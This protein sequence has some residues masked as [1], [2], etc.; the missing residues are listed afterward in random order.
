[1][2]NKILFLETP[3]HKMLLINYK[4]KMVIL[5]WR[6]MPGKKPQVTPG[7]GICNTCKSQR[8]T[9]S[10]GLCALLS[11]SVLSHSLQPHGLQPAG[12]LRPWGFSRQEYWSG[13]PC[14]SP[15]DLL[16]PGTEPKSRIVGGF[17]TILAT[18]EAI[19]HIPRISTNQHLYYSSM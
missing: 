10:Y 1:M 13:L 15:G 17:F 2:R 9:V 6:N 19:S 14:P 3:F 12:L 5:W 11:Q 7:E 18:R 4:E 8:V 16:N